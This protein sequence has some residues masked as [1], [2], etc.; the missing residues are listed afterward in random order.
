[1]GTFDMIVVIAFNTGQ[2]TVVERSFPTMEVCEAKRLEV[3]N[4]ELGRSGDKPARSLCVPRP[5]NANGVP[6][7]CPETMLREMNGLRA[8]ML[9]D[10]QR[11][12]AK[13]HDLEERARSLAC[14]L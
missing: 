4:S 8:A 7:A 3:S 14:Q 10:A 2:Y 12:L 6:L 1:M 9:V 5:G 11:A 13:M